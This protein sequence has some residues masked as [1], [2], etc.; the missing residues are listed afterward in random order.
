MGRDLW[1]NNERPK[2]RHLPS[3]LLSSQS[4]WLNFFVLADLFLSCPLLE[5]SWLTEV[6]EI[7][8]E[9]RSSLL[10]SSAPTSHMKS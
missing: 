6:W 9:M 5:L 7:V 4:T 1:V 10:T 2:G 8:R 3:G